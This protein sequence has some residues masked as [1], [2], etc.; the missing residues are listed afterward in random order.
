MKM[1]FFAML[2][3]TSLFQII[4]IE[5]RPQYDLQYESEE[6]QPQ[7]FGSLATAPVLIDPEGLPDDLLSPD[8][9]APAAPASFAV[10]LTHLTPTVSKHFFYLVH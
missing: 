3:L 4:L 5:A 8:A 2:A 1:V 9:A 7:Y 6:Y 10:D